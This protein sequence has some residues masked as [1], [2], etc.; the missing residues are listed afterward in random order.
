MRIRSETMTYAGR[1]NKE[2][3]DLLAQLELDIEN[4]NI[5]YEIDPSNDNYEVLLGYKKDL[6]DLNK[7]KMAGIIFRSKCDWAEYGE[8]NS[9]YFLNLEKYNFENKHI[10]SLNANGKITSDERSI[11]KY[12]KLLC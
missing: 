4:S 5:T 1:I 10:T 3:R 7:E 11:R 9:K 2:K 8:K 12:K 6:E